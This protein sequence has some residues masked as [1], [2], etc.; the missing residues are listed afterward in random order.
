MRHHAVSI[1]LA[2][3]SLSSLACRRDKPVPRDLRV[4]V[5]VWDFEDAVHSRDKVARQ[6]VLRRLTELGPDAVA[7][8]S[9]LLDH[10]NP[11][12]FSATMAVLTAP[13]REEA[14]EFAVL[15]ALAH[16]S[17]FSAGGPDRL[18]RLGPAAVR[19]LVLHYGPDLPPAT[20]ARIL[21]HVAPAATPDARRL[22]ERALGDSAPDVLAVAATWLG[23]LRGRDALARLEGLL[24]HP[25][26]DVRAGAIRGLD[27]LGDP[28]AVRALLA[29]LLEP[30]APIPVPF[31]AVN[32]AVESP[33]D[34]TEPQ[35]TLQWRSAL[36]IDH[37]AGTTFEGRIAPIQ[38]WL[39]EHPELQQAP[40]TRTPTIR[41]E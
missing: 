6:K 13:G 35:D 7:A 15:E 39:S 29:V 25:D 19:R 32:R 40:P 8:L 41:I 37:L 22:V 2:V 28:R 34:A 17:R 38:E 26:I 11:V 10:P 33:V 30:P 12:S 3:V 23:C 21:E 31:D 36:V 14:L 24:H 16:E 1:V 27:C 4:G 18:E 5:L 9:K 20:R